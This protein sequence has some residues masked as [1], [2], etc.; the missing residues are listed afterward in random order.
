MQPATKDRLRRVHFLVFLEKVY[1]WFLV[2]TDKHLFAFLFNLQSL[3]SLSSTRCTWNGSTFIVSD[4][5][6]PGVTIAIRSRWICNFNYKYG[7]EARARY[8]GDVYNLDKIGFRNGDT[9][10]DCGA[11][12]GDLNLWFDLEGLKINY[13][14]FEPS[15]VEF[16]CLKKN[17]PSGEM[18]NVGL[19]TEEGELEFFVNSHLADSSLIEPKRWNKKI[20]VRV[21]RLENYISDKVKLLKLEAEGA[22]PEILQGLG[23]K[24][25]LVEYISADLGFERGISEESTLVPVTNFLL[26]CGFELVDVSHGRVCAL[27]RNANAL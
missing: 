21:S 27:F 19:W 12:I 25:N 23:G 1:G 3:C 4:K 16:E 9:V 22:E 6:M 18:H 8:L 13:I 20:K 15:P 10:I 2:R 24:L 7:M 17:F 26:S 11:N 5:A 14:G